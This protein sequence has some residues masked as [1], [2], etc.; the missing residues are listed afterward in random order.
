MSYVSSRECG[1]P[2]QRDTSDLGITHIHRSAALL[3]CRC[4]GGSCSCRCAVEIQYAVFE[5]L[6]EQIV[7]GS[8]KDLSAPACRQQCQAKT[9]LEQCDAGYPNGGGWLPVQP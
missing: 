4:Q 6:P 2:R 8:L 1:A 3:S 5:I 7:K 9:R